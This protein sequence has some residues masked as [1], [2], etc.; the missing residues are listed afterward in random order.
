[1]SSSSKF[2]LTSSKRSGARSRAGWRKWARSASLRCRSWSKS[3]SA[4][5]GTRRTRRAWGQGALEQ[6]A[7]HLADDGCARADRIPAD[8]LFLLGHHEEEP[9]ERLLRDVLFQVGVF[10][11]HQTK[12]RDLLG[13]I[14][15]LLH[16]ADLLGRALD[17]RQET[18]A[19][20][21]FGS[22][23]E[24]LGARRVSALQDALC[25]LQRHL[26]DRV[27]E[28]LLCLGHRCLGGAIHAEN[29][30]VRVAPQAETAH[31][32]LGALHRLG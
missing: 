7:E 24:I 19:Q 29:Q 11:L 20:L 32:L 26:T 28:K 2:L 14:V 18:L 13:V 15:V 9:V 1:M 5:T 30:L 22:A 31:E 25:V 23:T 10:F 3:E 17:D 8:G 6:R 21:R 4:T 16:E 27:D 12:R